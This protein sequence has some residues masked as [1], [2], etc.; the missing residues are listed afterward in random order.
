MSADVITHVALDKFALKVFNCLVYDRE[1]SDPLVASYLLGLPDHYTLLNNVK[2]INLAIY[3]KR[4][5]EFVLHIYKLLLAVNDFVRLQYQTSASST[6]FDHY[7]C[8]MSRLQ[9][10]CLFVYMRIINISPQK[11]AN[12]NDI[13]F[14]SSH[15]RHQPHLQQHFMKSGSQAKVKLLGPWFGSDGLGNII[16]ADDF[17]IAES[18]NDIV[19][20]LIALFVPW[21]CLHS[22]FTDMGTTDD[23][24]SSLYWVIWYHCYSMFNDNVKYYATNIL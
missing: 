12:S 20:I 19:V 23:N 24:Y 21:D 6:M 8:Q 18:H 10:F 7:R 11:L 4:F 13:D 15:L 17:G 1:I 5:P 3:W 14:E 22:L 16:S 9:N 2:S